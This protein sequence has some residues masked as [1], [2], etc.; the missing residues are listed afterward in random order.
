MPYCVRRLDSTEQW[1]IAAPSHHFVSLRLPGSLLLHH[2]TLSMPTISCL[3]GG[4]KI[5]FQ[6]KEQIRADIRVFLDEWKLL[7][8]EYERRKEAPG[9]VRDLIWADDG[10][11][12]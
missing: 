6:K 1:E 4:W 9:Q 7:I 5:R 11:G 2:L 8:R 3:V 10:L 12:L